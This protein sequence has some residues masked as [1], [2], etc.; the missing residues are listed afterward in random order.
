MT[1]EQRLSKLL[2]N[3]EPSPSDQSAN[4][5]RHAS[6]DELLKTE[7]LGLENQKLRE[8]II[9]IQQDRDERKT[10]GSKVFYLIVC[11]L[12]AIFLLLVLDGCKVLSISDGVLGGLIATLAPNVLGLFY[13][14][15]KYLFAKSD[16]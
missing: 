14:V 5:V 16:K 3:G 9:D 1:E 7:K 10:Y 12:V 13:F 11:Y 8:Q 15:M 2:Q 4:A 6:A